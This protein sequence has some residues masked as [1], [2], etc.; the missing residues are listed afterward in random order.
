MRRS[1]QVLTGHNY[2][3]RD[4]EKRGI[5]TQNVGSFGVLDEIKSIPDG[6]DILSLPG[7]KL[8]RGGTYVSDQQIVTSDGGFIF[9]IPSTSLANEIVIQPNVAFDGD[10]SF[11]FDVS[12]STAGS[13]YSLGFYF[14]A[15]SPF[16]PYYLKAH[17][18]YSSFLRLSYISHATSGSSGYF[19]TAITKIR[20]TRT[21]S[22][23]YLYTYKPSAWTAFWNTAVSSGVLH[24]MFFYTTITSANYVEA[25][26]SNFVLNSGQTQVLW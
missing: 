4:N 9:D 21:G 22:T 7:F 14:Y 20:F 18:N 12:H 6:V 15:G 3:R 10:F 25:E 19:E 13:G 23:V 16:S 24:F 11:E 1:A 5:E 17:F 2:Y 26:Y 8:L